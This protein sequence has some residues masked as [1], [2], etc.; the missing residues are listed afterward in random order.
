[1]EFYSS[2]NN[3][4]RSNLYQFI[5]IANTNKPETEFAQ[6]KSRTSPVYDYSLSSDNEEI[7]SKHIC[8]PIWYNLDEEEVSK[9]LSQLER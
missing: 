8:L 3:K 4:Q 7:R 2:K 5:L 1:M 9:V 6:I